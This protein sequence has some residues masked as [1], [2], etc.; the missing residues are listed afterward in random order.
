[1]IVLR[2]PKGWTD[3]KELDGHRL[4]GSWRSHQIPIA[5]PMTNPAHLKL[6]EQWMRSYGPEELF[7]EGGR[8]VEELREIA[9]KGQRRISANPHANGGTISKPLSLPDFR[10][11]AVTVEKPGVVHGDAGE[12]SAGC[13]AKE[14]DELPGV[15]AG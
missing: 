3:P 4:E 13:G 12:V 10:E 11:Y 8:L 7:D 15:W 6:V 1:M 5:D 2:S 9:P 14:H